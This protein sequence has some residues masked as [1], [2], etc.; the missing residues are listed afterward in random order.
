MLSGFTQREGRC[1]PILETVMS[2]AMFYTWMKMRAVGV[3]FGEGRLDK[4]SL[5]FWPF[6]DL[7][8]LSYGCYM[9][10][11]TQKVAFWDTSK[12][13]KKLGSEI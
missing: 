6:W 1:N 12:G 3:T 13:W 11:S 10:A 5:S 8:V 2:P 9:S 4:Q 7:A